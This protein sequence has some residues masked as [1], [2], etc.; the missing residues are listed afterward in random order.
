MCIA[1]VFSKLKRPLAGAALLL[2]AGC[3]SPHVE[4]PTDDRL[5]TGTLSGSANQKPLKTNGFP[6]LFSE[7]LD[8]RLA[9]IGT[10]PYKIGTPVNGYASDFITQAFDLYDSDAI[11]TD[12]W[13]E[14]WGGSK[15]CDFTKVA[16]FADNIDLS[17]F[18]W[19][20]PEAGDVP[21]KVIDDHTYQFTDK[22]K[23]FVHFS[24]DGYFVPSGGHNGDAGKFF[25]PVL[26]FCTLKEGFVWSA[27]KNKHLTSYLNIKGDRGRCFGEY[28]P[29]ITPLFDR[30]FPG[31]T[32]GF[33]FYEG[34]FY[35]VSLRLFEYSDGRSRSQGHSRISIVTTKISYN[36]V[37]K[38][39]NMERVCSFGG[40]RK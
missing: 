25:N 28:N 17:Q 22:S 8:L 29:D 23:L 32:I 16:L 21:L 38:I 36:A 1:S 34:D 15:V 3:E 9:N 24:Y 7:D 20:H 31:S 2:V 39:T 11:F 40:T 4:A 27:D 30:N 12:R 35:T 13:G 19:H 18:Y 10:G 6:P 5:Q 14:D 33:F 26:Q 37:P